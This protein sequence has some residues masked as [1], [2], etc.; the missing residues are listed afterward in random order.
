MHDFMIE[1]FCMLQDCV[2]ARFSSIIAAALSLNVE[3]KVKFV[4]LNC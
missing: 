3:Y 2:N 4:L 1:L